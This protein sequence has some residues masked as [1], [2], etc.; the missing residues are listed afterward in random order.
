MT[1]LLATM[2][3]LS[4]IAMSVGLIWKAGCL[5]DNWVEK[6]IKKDEWAAEARAWLDM[7]GEVG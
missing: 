2:I 7:M 5:S 3:G 1:D 6:E 4:C